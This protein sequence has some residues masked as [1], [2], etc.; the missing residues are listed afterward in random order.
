MFAGLTDGYRWMFFKVTRLGTSYQYEQSTVFRGIIGWRHFLGMLCAPLNELRA[1]TPVVSMT[2]LSDITVERVLGAGS[3]SVVYEA[4]M[5]KD[6]SDNDSVEHALVKVYNPAHLAT[7]RESEATVLS[8]LAEAKVENV[9]VLVLEGKGTSISPMVHRPRPT[10]RC[11]R[12]IGHGTK[13]IPFDRRGRTR[14]LELF[15]K[16][17]GGI[18]VNSSLDSRECRK[19][20]G[21]LQSLRFRNLSKMVAL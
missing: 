3:S 8:T 16:V 1:V 7:T 17:G 21:A 2:G 10:Y 15:G 13:P 9:P 12:C 11:S 18:R 5:K 14:V 19:L 6:L 4:K 20:R